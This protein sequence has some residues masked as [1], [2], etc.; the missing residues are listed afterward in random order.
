MPNQN[1]AGA[2][3]PLN[4]HPLPINKR[5]T[6][7]MDARIVTNLVEDMQYEVI[8]VPPKGVVREISAIATQ[9]L[10]NG[11]GNADIDEASI[12]LKDKS[13][14]LWFLS[15]LT[16][17][18]LS[19]GDASDFSGS[20]PLF[21]LGEDDFF[22][23]AFLVLS[24]GA[25]PGVISAQAHWADV[26]NVI[27]KITELSTSNQRISPE[28]PVGNV[29]VTPGNDQVPQTALPI[30]NFDNIDHNVVFELFNGSVSTVVGTTTVALSPEPGVR[31]SF[32]SPDLATVVVPHGWELRARLLES[33]S[34]GGPV[35]APQHLVLTN[36]APVRQDQGGAY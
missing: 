3:Q 9:S 27:R 25:G 10:Y 21:L 33:L 22:E 35:F 31:A 6:L 19:A 4:Q 18:A 16:G 29:G 13:G 15:G 5:Y 23:G 8:P 1:P 11:E 20:W 24:G 2:N 17:G 14:R 30:Y 36:Y 32:T 26:R 12:Y 7:G 34:D 28:I